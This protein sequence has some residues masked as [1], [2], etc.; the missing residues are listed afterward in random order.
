MEAIV[1]QTFGDV[2]LG[3][4]ARLFEA[5]AVKNELV[6]NATLITSVDNWVV[7][8]KTVGNVVSIQDGNLAGLH[9]ARFSQELDERVADGENTSITIWC[10]GDG[11]FSATSNR[12][13]NMSGD[14]W[15]EVNFSTDRTNTGTTT[16]VR[17]SEG[18]VQVEMTNVSADV[19]WRGKTELSVK[20]GTIHVDL[21]AL[22]V[23]NFTDLL[24]SS[25]KH[26]MC[27]WVGD[28][29]T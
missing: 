23:D 18:L 20:V 21:T 17:D 24:D 26:A 5:G 12:C 15:L 14:E 22:F 27:G 7:V 9:Q 3:D 29:G 13:D 16:T 2:L 6:G 8:L 1:H 19:T 25:L 28:H 11:T 10:G 4:A